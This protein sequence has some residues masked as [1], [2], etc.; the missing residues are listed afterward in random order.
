MK[1]NIEINKQINEIRKKFGKQP[2]EKV[3]E[4]ED[5]VKESKSREENNN[6]KIKKI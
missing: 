5:Y 3:K 2:L 6:I 1:N 4:Y